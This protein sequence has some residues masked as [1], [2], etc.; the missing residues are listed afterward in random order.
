MLRQPYLDAPHLHLVANALAT[1]LALCLVRTV[2]RRLGA[3]YGAYV[4]ALMVGAA[5]STK[6]FVGMGRYAVAA[7]PLFAVAGE[8]LADRPKLARAVLAGSAA[9]LLVTTQLHAR[10]LLIS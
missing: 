2:F 10:N 8:R 6:D 7:F 5:L 1:V 9:L 3:G 4:V